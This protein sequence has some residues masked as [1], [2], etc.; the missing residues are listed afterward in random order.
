MYYV[1]SFISYHDCI[2]CNY[3]SFHM[4]SHFNFIDFVNSVHY[5]GNE[6]KK[7][8]ER[9][10]GKLWEQSH[11]EKLSFCKNSTMISFKEICMGRLCHQP[12][13]CNNHNDYTYVT[14]KDYPAYID[15]YCS[16]VYM[17]QD[18]LWCVDSRLKRTK[19]SSLAS[20]FFFLLNSVI[21]VSNIKWIKSHH[22]ATKEPRDSYWVVLCHRVKM[23]V[24]ISLIRHTIHLIKSIR[25]NTANELLGRHFVLWTVLILSACGAQLGVFA[26]LKERLLPGKSLLPN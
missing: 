4:T 11:L 3:L 23:F 2:N 13:Q 17:I 16:M 7:N 1:I 20:E 18:Q 21:F 6:K 5:C 12:D 14:C 25:S 22:Y 9:N 24:G 8:E 15:R 19:E 10:E 26:G